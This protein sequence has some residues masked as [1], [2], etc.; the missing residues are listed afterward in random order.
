M[1]QPRKPNSL[2][3]VQ[4]FLY[5]FSNQNLLYF[6]EKPTRISYTFL[7]NQTQPKNPYTSLEK[8]A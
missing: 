3:S 7:K 5:F 4:R 8:P 1:E 6:T 2:L